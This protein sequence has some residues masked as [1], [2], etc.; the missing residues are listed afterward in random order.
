MSLKLNTTDEPVD[1]HTTRQG[2]C[3]IKQK[4]HFAKLNVPVTHLTSWTVVRGR[5]QLPTVV[6]VLLWL[7]M[8]LLRRT[9]Y[10]C[11][12]DAHLPTDMGLRFGGLSVVLP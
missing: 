5:K 6:L 7:T 12:Y 9:H 3:L 8:A 2:E 10:K 4:L 1:C 11:S